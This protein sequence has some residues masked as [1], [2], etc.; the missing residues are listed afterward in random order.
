MQADCRVMTNAVEVENYI[1][2]CFIPLTFPGINACLSSSFENDIYPS[3]LE[4]N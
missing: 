4:Q 1:T 3:N 2:N